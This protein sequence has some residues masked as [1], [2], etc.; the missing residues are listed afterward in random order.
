[1]RAIDV[2]PDARERYRA[3]CEARHVGNLPHD[4]REVYLSRVLLR[5]GK[6]EYKKLYEALQKR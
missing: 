5:R 1:V 3:E 2:P 4:R 6:E